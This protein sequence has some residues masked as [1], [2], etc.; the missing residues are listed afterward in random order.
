MGHEVDDVVGEQ[1]GLDAGDAVTL[2]AFDGI[3]AAQQVEEALAV[4][5]AEGAGVDAC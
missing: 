1:V 2:N 5:L 4:L 3:E